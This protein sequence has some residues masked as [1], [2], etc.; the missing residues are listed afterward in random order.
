LK[1]SQ[2]ATLGFGVI[3]SA[4]LMAASQSADEVTQFVRAEMQQQ[5]IPGLTLLVSRS[6]KPIRT[7]GYGLSNVE[8]N[9]P[10]KP[11]SIFQSGSVG[12][13][14]TATAVMMLVEARCP[15]VPIFNPAPSARRLIGNS[16]DHCAP[17]PSRSYGV[18]SRSRVA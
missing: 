15:S 8:L 12:K 9:V 13:Q 5:H 2:F 4:Q 16:L 18:P 3:F 6:G 14:F 11:E 1:Y 7:E 10:A 17:A